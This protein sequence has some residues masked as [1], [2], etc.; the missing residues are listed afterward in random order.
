MDINYQFLEQTFYLVLAAVP[1][2]L[3]LTVTSLLLS[4]PLAF[5][6]ALV[7]LRRTRYVSGFV[8]SYI[9]LLRGTPASSKALYASCWL[10]EPF[11]I[12]TVLPLRS[13]TD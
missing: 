3:N 6:M 2:T 4:L 5:F 1:T 11:Q 8:G 13:A 9:T 10:H 7:C 12:A